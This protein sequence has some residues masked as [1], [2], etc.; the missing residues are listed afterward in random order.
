MRTSTY[1]FKYR[2][3]LYPK[4]T[5]GYE[6]S[7]WY[8][9]PDVYQEKRRPIQDWL[10]ESIYESVFEPRD[11]FSNLEDNKCYE[12]FGEGSIT[13]GWIWI[14]YG[15][16]YDEDI[17]LGEPQVQEIPLSYFGYDEITND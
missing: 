5:D 2:I 11:Y 8:D 16:E 14:D 7:V 17:D 13:G 3:I 1:E 12:L 9:K 6:L 10:Q 4:D 15:E